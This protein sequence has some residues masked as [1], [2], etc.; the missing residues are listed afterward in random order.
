MLAISNV[1]GHGFDARQ[2]GNLEAL[3]F[4]LR[5]KVSRYMGAQL[6]HFI[7]FVAGPALE[8]IVVEDHRAYRDFVPEGMQP[9]CPGISLVA[10]RGSH[11][12]LE[13]YEQAFGELQPYTLH[14]NYDGSLAPAQPGWNYLNFAIPVVPGTFTWLTALDDPRPP[15]A[16]HP[17]AHPNRVTGPIGLVFDLDADDL[18]G[19]ARL[20]SGTF[21]GGM[22]TV[23][24]VSVWLRSALDDFPAQDEKAFPLIAIV[25]KAESLDYFATREGASDVSFMSQPA[26]H[27]ATNPQSWDVMVVA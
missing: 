23:G 24:E 17:T 3:G 19:L 6:C 22:L 27:I 21:A 26:I 18:Q 10:A 11:L 25:L 5:P 16:A 8:L 12:S 13:T 2:L 15:H 20:V 4:R 7:D 9:Y 14:V 1:Y